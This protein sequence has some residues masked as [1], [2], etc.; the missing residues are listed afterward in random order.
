MLFGGRGARRMAR[1][2]RSGHR[3]AVAGPAGPG[4][5]PGRLHDR[6]SSR[7]AHRRLARHHRRPARA[8]APAHAVHRAAGLGRVR[9]VRHRVEHAGCGLVGRLHGRVGVRRSLPGARCPRCARVSEWA[10]CVAARARRGRRRLCRDG[11]AARVGACSGLRSRRA[12]VS[13]MLR[14]PGRDLQRPRSAPLARQSRLEARR[15]VGIG[16]RR[17]RSL[18]RGSFDAGGAPAQ[19]ADPPGGRRLPRCRGPH[20]CP[21]SRR[22][23]PVQRYGRPPPVARPGHRPDDP[24]GGRRRGGG[25]SSS[26][27]FG[28]CRD[29]GRLGPGARIGRTPRRTGGKARRSGARDRLSARRRPPC[30]RARHGGRRAARAGQGTGDDRRDA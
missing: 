22:R 1:R 7:A 9:L 28:G 11:R 10:T 2:D 15:R 12:G 24:R 8:S 25:S 13:P 14:Q 26:R 4:G 21:S 20:V 27:S 3:H 18:A 6:G 5:V 29:G 16:A 30:G 23:W 19:G 17:S